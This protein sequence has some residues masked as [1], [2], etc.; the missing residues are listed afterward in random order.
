VVAGRAVAIEHRLHEA[1]E[2]ERVGAV[3]LGQDLR[4]R[5]AQGGGRHGR[6]AQPCTAGQASGA[7]R[8]RRPVL[9]LVAALAGEPLARMDVGA[10]AHRLDGQA[11]AIQ[12]LE[13]DLLAHRGL[14][15]RAA[16]GLDRHRAEHGPRV[17]LLGDADPR[18]VRR[19]RGLGQHLDDAQRGDLRPGWP[20]E[21]AVVD[22]GHGDGRRRG[23]VAGA[24]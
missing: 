21:V 11:V 14:E 1:H 3:G 17:G 9:G 8:G 2:A 6:V 10:R 12:G 24:G 19:R 23:L 22:I 15:V 13:V 16:V 5:P 7:T 4:R 20:A 18:L